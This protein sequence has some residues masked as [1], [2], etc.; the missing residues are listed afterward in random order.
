VVAPK[1][2][3]REAGSVGLLSEEETVQAF[4]MIDDRNLTSHT[5]HEEIAE[6]I[7]KKLPH[8][9]WDYEKA[10]SAIPTNFTKSRSRRDA[11]KINVGMSIPPAFGGIKLVHNNWSG[12]RRHEGVILEIS[13]MAVTPNQVRSHGQKRFPY[14]S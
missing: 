9:F 1:S 12:T 11:G 4:E 6:E 3:F 10:A 7:Y 5:Y 2:C 8:L 13:R 14:I